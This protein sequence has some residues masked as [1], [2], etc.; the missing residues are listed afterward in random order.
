MIKLKH[1]FIKTNLKKKYRLNFPSFN[2]TYTNNPITEL[3][4]SKTPQTQ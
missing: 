2:I 1:I 3:K 4:E